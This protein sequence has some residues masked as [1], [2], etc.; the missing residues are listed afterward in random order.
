MPLR[1]NGREN[2]IETPNALIPPVEGQKYNIVAKLMRRGSSKRY[3]FVK[4]YVFWPAKSMKPIRIPPLR[5]SSTLMVISKPG[6]IL[7]LTALAG[8]IVVFELS[9]SESFVG[10]DDA[11]I[12]LC[13]IDNL[14][15]CDGFGF[16]PRG[17]SN[18]ST[19]PL[20]VLI[21]ALF[22][23]DAA[24][25]PHA[26][27]LLSTFLFVLSILPF[28][29]LSKHLTHSSEH[30]VLPTL[31][32]GSDPWLLKWAGS[33]METSLI[34]LLIL[35]AACFLVRSDNLRNSAIASFL[36]G[37]GTL[38]RPEVALLFALSLF[39]TIPSRQAG[40]ALFKRTST[41]LAIYAIVLT[42]WLLYALVTFGS[43]LPN[44]F[45]AKITSSEATIWDT[46]WYFARIISVTY[47]PWLLVLASLIF[48]F[49][50][51]RLSR[52]SSYS[53]FKTRV[54]LMFWLWCCLIVAFYI[55]G[56]LQTPSTRYLQV[57]TPILI[58]VGFGG[59]VHTTKSLPPLQRSN[60]LRRFITILVTSAVVLYNVAL[61]AL[62]VFPSSQDFA[63]GVLHT[64]KRV[65]EWLNDHASAR[66]RVAVTTDVGVIGYY[67]RCE[68]IDLCGLN[69]PEAIPY[70][71]D[72]L[73]YVLV[74]KPDYLVNTG[75]NQPFELTNQTR[76]RGV[77]VP[78]LSLPADIGL[79]A[80]LIAQ[81]GRSSAQVV[82]VSLYRLIWPEDRQEH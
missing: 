5:I 37:L 45:T 69:S 28:Y 42:P 11:Y 38:V 27:K 59:L 66:S 77:A 68:I 26:V 14:R 46:G 61:N 43:V 30:A 29:A 56:K 40:G 76:F 9:I 58:S 57:M 15:N 64:Y 54:V 34:A 16:N 23:S 48:L 7:C 50:R 18:G 71:E 67:S 63:R 25:L 80:E 22:T 79:R 2:Q 33:T 53:P 47:W 35:A 49:F 82:H 31:I 78:V 72:N 55:L 74:S 17:P 13:Y 60:G 4:K 36:L 39:L 21:A 70:L 51:K 41:M 81:T 19:S 1:A 8:L 52:D 3:R 20:W 10:A 75:E 12:H 6:V 32:Y 73:K 65:A 24:N 44:T 62:V